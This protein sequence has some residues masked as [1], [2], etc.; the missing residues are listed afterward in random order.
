MSTNEELGWTPE[1]ER[2]G[3][4]RGKGRTQKKS[5]GWTQ[6]KSLV[7]HEQG[8]AFYTNEKLVFT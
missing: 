3:H 1:E 6:R 4:K 2:L 8:A 5:G 7:G